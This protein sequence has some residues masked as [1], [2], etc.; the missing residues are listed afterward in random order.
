MKYPNTRVCDIGVSFIFSKTNN[1][2]IDETA[3]IENPG[4]SC[5]QTGLQQGDPYPAI[6]LAQDKTAENDKVGA[7]NK[8]GTDNKKEEIDRKRLCNGEIYFIEEV[9]IPIELLPF[10]K[11]LS[12][13]HNGSVV[14]CLTQ[15][16][17]AAGSRL[18]GVTALCP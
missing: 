18:S 7:E 10:Q 9:S 8:Q 3:S 17:R 4:T 2:L 16:K 11:T 14:E 6:P 15:D 5:R 13:E 12:W 1:T